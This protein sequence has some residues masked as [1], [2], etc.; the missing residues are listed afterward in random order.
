MRRIQGVV[1]S[2][3][4]EKAAIVRVERWVTH[5]L[6]K[7]RVRRHKKFHAHNALG[8]KVGDKVVMVETKPLSKAKRWKIVEVANDST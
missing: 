7:K 2:D 4:M 6:Y 8:A 5:P 1:V 3:K